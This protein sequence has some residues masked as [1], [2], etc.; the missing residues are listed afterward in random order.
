MASQLLIVH[1]YS[2]GSTSFTALGDFLI[3]QGLYAD[4]HVS[5]VDYSSMDDE[6]TFHDFADKLDTD[7]RA[8]FGSE[9]VDVV[10]HSTGSLVVRAWL[11]LHAERARRRALG[12]GSREACPV[13]RLVCFAPANFGSDLAALGQSFLAKFRTT[14]FNSHSHHEDALETGK[15]V[16]QGLEPASPFQW[17]LSFNYDLH[18]AFSYF[19]ERQPEHQR[20]YPFVLAA[21]EAYSGVQARLIPQRR[22]PGTDGT[23]RIAGT[24]LNSRACSLDFRPEGAAL[25]WWQ[26]Q[27]FAS[28]P[29]A[30][31]AGVNHGSIIDPACEAFSHPDG[32]GALV[33]EALREPT[34][35][36]SY[37]T[38]AERFAEASMRN[39]ARLPPDRQERFQQ[40]FFRVRDD[41]DHLVNDYYIDFH[42]VNRDGTPNEP[43]TVQ[44]D[45]DFK[46]KV[47]LHSTTKSHRVFMMSCA[48]LDTFHQ[49][50]RQHDAQLV[51]EV[52]GVSPL[53]DVQYV[54]SR[55]VAYDPAAPVNSHEPAL[56]EPNT[57]TLVDVI[58]NRCQTDKLATI[59]QGRPVAVEDPN[60]T[61]AKTKATGRAAMVEERRVP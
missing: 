31:L 14:F 22:M 6:A 1:G 25:V 18:G 57:T 50:L 5:Y 56:L 46:T 44:F 8:R 35:L 38:L 28:I 36:A 12:A 33:L 20:C 42:V 39:Q 24:S 23:V 58:L 17:D 15:V 59:L 2:D 49:A 13:D 19:H 51:L 37:Q 4:D 43:L 26:G 45:E 40:F 55:F 53:P 32:P 16:L 30:V 52:T 48:K 27:K 11:A 41:V 3:A 29:F 7:H 21:G 47:T 9:R 60:K 34:T 54:T 61:I 10:C